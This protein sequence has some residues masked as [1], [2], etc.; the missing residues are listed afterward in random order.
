MEIMEKSSPQK[1]SYKQI[2]RFNG[3]NYALLTSHC[4]Y[5]AINLFVNT[6]LV[7]HIYSLSN[8][9]VIDIG[10][11]YLG[12][13]FV[14]AFTYL[15]A[16]MLIEK[17]NRVTF[18]RIANLIKSIFI[19]SVV[20]LG[21]K[22]ATMSILAGVLNGFA[23]GM[24][25]TS[26]NIMKNE[27]IPNAKMKTY[28]TIQ[29][30]DERVVNLVVPLILGKI[31]DADSFKLSAI[32][33]AVMTVV[34]FFVSL[35]I[36]SKRPAGSKFD[37]K[38]FVGRIK[39][40][41]EKGK[42]VTNNI[43]NAGIYGTL[44]ILGPINTIIIMIG[45]DSNFSL[46]IFTS[47]SSVLA[48]FYLLWLSNMTKP[49]KRNAYYVI[50]SILPFIFALIMVLHLNKVTII[51][52]SFS[53]TI[54][55]MFRSHVY[56]VFRNRLLKRLE[57]YEDIPEYQCAVEF[58]MEIGRSFVFVLMIVAGALGSIWGT[59]GILTSL[60]IMLILGT[61]LFAFLNVKLH[62]Y[63]KKVLELDLM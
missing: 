35:F 38:G 60:K 53:Y 21:N 48:M 51:L 63:E 36:K 59:E 37:L 12:S 27:L 13:Y 15:F 18:Y 45:Y 6:F 32:I 26:Y 20:F 34:Q 57:L 17:T 44:E 39:S 33:V 19:I 28:S 9:Y 24:Y 47:I 22:L 49:G 11:F 23:E 25:W 5:N 16:S 14:M 29:L 43:V 46:G 4:L 52:F 55:N 58:F 3:S 62:S 31:I 41:G 30:I 2:E 56:D 40:L 8:N 54:C 42:L 1:I 50:S 61:V 7:S 10:L